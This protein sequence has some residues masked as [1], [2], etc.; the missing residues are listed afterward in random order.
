[1]TKAV[2]ME[3]F[4]I[5]EPVISIPLVDTVVVCVIVNDSKDYL[6][7]YLSNQTTQ[8]ETRLWNT[9]KETEVRV[10]R[11]KEEVLWSW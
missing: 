3:S 7:F 6:K 1:M 5:L 9:A 2:Q 8:I 11:V 4:L 10:V